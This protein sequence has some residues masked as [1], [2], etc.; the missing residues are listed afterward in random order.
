MR[1]TFE[2]G[3]KPFNRMGMMTNTSPFAQ[4]SFETTMQFLT[5]ACMTGD[6]DDLKNP[7]ARIVMG[8]VVKSGTGGQFDIMQKI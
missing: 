5:S 7:S 4:M 6:Y 8:Q 3:Y 2:G 1:K